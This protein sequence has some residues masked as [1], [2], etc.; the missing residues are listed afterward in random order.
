M[1]ALSVETAPHFVGR[2]IRTKGNNG[3][4]T[5]KL[6]GLR[7]GGRIAIVKPSKHHQEEDMPVEQLDAHLTFNPDLRHL[8]DKK[9]PEASVAP[10]SEH[11]HFPLIPNAPFSYN[12][13]T[14]PK[15]KDDFLDSL[16]R[17]KGIQEE[18][19][20]LEQRLS[21]KKSELQEARISAVAM[22]DLLNDVLGL[23]APKKTTVRPI[24]GAS[25]LTCDRHRDMVEW[26]RAN[27]TGHFARSTLISG[28][29]SLPSFMSTSTEALETSVGTILERSPYFHRV[30]RGVYAFK[31]VS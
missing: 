28:V 8:F 14:T 4:N 11:D 20:L 30:E 16:E 3:I 29:R 12:A 6:I 15:S 18:I 21:T 22:R 19:L 25:S 10:P 7:P 9:M 26:A 5:A 13:P 1:P 2:I 31:E 23:D 27:T 17:I 24:P